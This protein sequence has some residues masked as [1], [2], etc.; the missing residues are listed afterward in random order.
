LQNPEKNKPPKTVGIMGAGGGCGVTH[1]AVL[2][3]NYLAAVELERIAVIEWNPRND[4]EKLVNIYT[5]GKNKNCP[6]SLLDIDY[7]FHGGPEEFHICM[8]QG[9]QTVLLDLG[10]AGEGRETE[11]L[12][13]HK[14]C[15]FFA[16][17]EWKL[18]DVTAQKNLWKKGKGRWDFFMV[19][20]S[21]EA[22]QEICR[23]YGL[24]V[25]QIPFAPDAFAI[26]RETAEF[27]DHFW[28]RK[29]I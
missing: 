16:L 6:V 19:F 7:F 14:Q 28:N 12:Q 27:F 10:R 21:R 20:G 3:A 13:C 15:F 5:R 1:F 26:K 24:K 2:L 22:R 25:A 29:E 4:L 17:N 8:Q 23:R 11:F 18:Q 9:Y